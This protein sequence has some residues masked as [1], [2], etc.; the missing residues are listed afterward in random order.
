VCEIIAEFDRVR[1]GR[2]R[3]DIFFGVVMRVFAGGF[4]KNGVQRVVF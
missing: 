1:F 2:W 4:G 3:A